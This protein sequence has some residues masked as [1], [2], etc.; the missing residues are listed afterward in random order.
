MHYIATQSET[1]SA[2]PTAGFACALPDLL[3]N[4]TKSPSPPPFELSEDR[5]HGLLNAKEGL[6][7]PVTPSGKRLERYALQ[8]AVRDIL[9]ASRTAFCLRALRKGTTSVPVM[10]SK[11]CKRGSYRNLQV[12]S[13]VWRCPV[14]TA[15]ISER[16]RVELLG[17]MDAHKAAGGRLYLCTFTIPHHETDALADLQ[18]MLKKAENSFKSGKGWQTI[19]T[20]FGVL[21]TARAVEITYGKNGWHPHSHHIF[22]TSGDVD[23]AELKQALFTKWTN[24]CVASGLGAPSF[25][26]GVDVR[27]GTH[28]AS[29]AAKF[30]LEEIKQWGLENELTKWHSK[31]G[32]STSLTPFDFLRIYTQSD[33][34]RMRGQARAKFKEYAEALHGKRQLFISPKLKELYQVE[35]KSDDEA[36]QETDPDAV[37]LARLTLDGWRAVRT[38]NLRGELLEV[39]GFNDPQ[40]LHSFLLSRCPDR[41]FTDLFIPV[42]LE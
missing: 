6:V 12:C 11:A 13:S 32:R 10:Y 22:F 16:R 2:A 21:G 15:K 4:T 29:Y 42:F 3:G 41:V 30:G 36:A 27:D 24:S 17:L 40:R 9:P 20:K 25:E 8:S 31:K 18:G 14:C 34:L 5:G 28:A 23:I 33:D 7:Y 39:A 19:Q 38:L 37:E 26:H 35:E 1:P